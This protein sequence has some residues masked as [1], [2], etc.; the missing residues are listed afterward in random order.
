MSDLKQVKL[1]PPYKQS[2]ERQLE[3]AEAELT[4]LETQMKAKEA[5]V[6]VLRERVSPTSGTAFLNAWKYKDIVFEGGV[7]LSEFVH[8]PY[9]ERNAAASNVK[10][11]A[12]FIHRSYEDEDQR[13]NMLAW[14]QQTN[15]NDET[16][17]EM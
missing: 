3:L 6:K 15:D 9:K 5:L 2:L 7:R 13:E 10:L 1:K 11:L 12:E 8:L 14:L 16:L 17:E 4:Q